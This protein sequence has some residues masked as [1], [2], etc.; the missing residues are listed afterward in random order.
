MRAFGFRLSSMV[1]LSVAALPALSW[2]AGCSDP[3]SQIPQ[4]A[5]RPAGAGQDEPTGTIGLQLTLPDGETI[6]S[7]NYVLTNAQG[8]VV[9]SGSISTASSQSISFQLGNVPPGA[10]YNVSLTASTKSG[11]NCSGSSGPFAV[12]AHATT[13]V[14]LNAACYTPGSDAGNVLV[15]GNP[16][17][18][19]TW[20]SLSTVDPTHQ[21]TAGNET[22]VGS[23][24]TLQA[25][26]A[27]PDPRNITYT[28]S[29]SNNIGTFGQNSPMGT[30]DTV[31]FQCTAPG[32]TTITLVVGDGVLPDGASCST[33]A[34]T[35]TTVVTCDALAV[36]L[37]VDSKLVTS[38]TLPGINGGAP[39]T[40]G[41]LADGRA[42]TAA[43][44][45]N[46]VILS[47]G[48]PAALNAFL[49]RWN[50]TVLAT[51]DFA[52]AGLSLP[53][54]YLVSIDSS[55]ANESAIAVDIQ[56]V[57]GNGG[58]PLR[59]SS[60]TALRTM[61]V[62]A[63]EVA[64]NA[65]SL[66]LNFT[67]T[68]SSVATDLANRALT[69]APSGSTDPAGRAYS[70]NPF[71]WPYMTA[72]SVDP[73]SVQD[74]GVVEAW[75]DLALVGR[76]ANAGASTPHVTVMVMDGGFWLNPDLPAVQS[77][78]PPNAA[79]QSNPWPC[80]T[81]NGA[82]CE[83]HGTAVAGT[84]VGQ[85]DN[86]Y[87]TAG[88]GGP[89]SNLVMVE[90]PAADLFEIISYATSALPSALENGPAVVNMSFE[91]EVPGFLGFLV[92]A[93]SS[94]TQALRA[95]DV[96]VIVAAGNKQIDVDATDSFGGRATL[97]LPCIARGVDC[98]G[99][100]AWNSSSA[101]T[102]SSVGSNFGTN[103]SVGL[104]APW[105]VWAGPDPD[106]PG[107]AARIESGT[108]MSS[109]FVAGIAALVIA[110]DPAF[111]TSGALTADEV[112]QILLTT[113]HTGSPD[114]HV[115]RWVNAHA[116]VQAALSGT[117]VCQP[118]NV[119]I[120][121]PSDGTVVSPGASV[122]LVASCS[123]PCGGTPVITWSEGGTNLGTGPT[124]SYASSTFG[125]HTVLASCSGASA[126]PGQATVQIFVG[127]PCGI[128]GQA[129]CT[130]GSAC[131]SGSFC[132][133]SSVCATC[134]GPSAPVQVATVTQTFHPACLSGTNFTI[135]IGGA[136]APGFQLD[137]ADSTAVV[138]ATYGSSVCVFNPTGGCGGQLL[139]FADSSALCGVP[140]P[141]TLECTATVFEVPIPPAGC[142]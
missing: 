12:A 79:S 47:T 61:G 82:G 76:V 29:S 58:G 88:T 11:L 1:Q 102:G 24:I 100:L 17:N 30:S 52:A 26:A 37:S 63:K 6:S 10:S 77:I 66:N 57:S 41:V 70:P 118:P 121:S 99:G 113:A 16:Y 93:M 13:T 127:A 105:D 65:L 34:D 81:G 89:V 36:S 130:S 119:S 69:E 120:S 46:E 14:L 53:T 21:G 136:C 43:F 2:G 75:R 32:T 50:G 7:V 90:S 83:W 23:S 114:P 44:V 87:G 108:S 4:D 8:S 28:W 86:D 131:S 129:C 31:S 19:A 18:C 59:L 142:P 25:T 80:S 78:F 74:I 117:T 111:G 103:G 85:I 92:D 20:N 71:H 96:L 106:H 97:V 5:L 27:A 49:S 22:D 139:A 72:F 122:S 56:A 135:P 123:D 35:A 73:T 51:T 109:P 133:A 126:V 15:N 33:T 67:V 138:N 124:L 55:A 39:R 107:L 115:P 45:E 62:V 134:P 60:D 95:R 84:A 137:F 3:A 128:P 9:Q 94:F 48:D 38:T 54:M 40:L 140:S 101:E 116:A 141:P 132:D 42:T 125:A 64:Q 91:L 112:E 98:I 104:F 110:A 68:P